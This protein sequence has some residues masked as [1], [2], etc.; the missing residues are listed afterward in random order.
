MKAQGDTRVPDSGTVRQEEQQFL[1]GFLEFC[2]QTEPG[3][4]GGLERHGI[5]LG[6]IIPFLPGT[7]THPEISHSYVSLGAMGFLPEPISHVIAQEFHFCRS[8][9]ET[10]AVPL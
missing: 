9:E 6:C 10:L 7:I 4:A 3:R 8:T 2:Q 5:L 1:F